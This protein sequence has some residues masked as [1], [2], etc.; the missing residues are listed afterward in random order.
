MQC[1]PASTFTLFLTFSLHHRV[2]GRLV[3]IPNIQPLQQSLQLPTVLLKHLPGTPRPVKPIPPQPLLPRCSFAS[4][5]SPLITFLKSVGHTATH[6]R[7]CH[8]ISSHSMLK[9]R[10]KSIRGPRLKL[11]S[12]FHHVA[13][14]KAKL[15][16]TA[17]PQHR[18]CAHNP[19]W[20]RHQ[21]C[22]AARRSQE[23]QLPIGE[24]VLRQPL[25]SLVLGLQQVACR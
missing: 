24:G 14:G 8:S 19:S 23:L 17:S 1:R 3:R 11:R 9:H 7:A 25:L 4:T 10:Q 5:A 20:H 2:L 16:P 13:T 21:G 18:S 22:L 6:T 12:Q 15:N